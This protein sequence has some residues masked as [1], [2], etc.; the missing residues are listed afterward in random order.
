MRQTIT[1]RVD[2]K[3]VLELLSTLPIGY[4]QTIELFEALGYTIS[5]KKYKDLTNAA[6]EWIGVETIT[7]ITPDCLE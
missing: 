1:L 2:T 4:S 6:G 3:R 5:N 7:R